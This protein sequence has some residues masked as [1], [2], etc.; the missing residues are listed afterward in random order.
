MLMSI[1]TVTGDGGETAILYQSQILDRRMRVPLAVMSAE[2]YRRTDGIENRISICSFC[3][4]IAW[5]AGPSQEWISADD[6][7]AKGGSSQAGVTHGV[8]PECFDKSQ[9]VWRQHPAQ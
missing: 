7:Y 6:Y 4:K 8:C 5:P 3:A 9:N 1:S 2:N